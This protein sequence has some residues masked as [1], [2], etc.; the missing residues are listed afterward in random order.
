MEYDIYVGLFGTK[1]YYKKG[2]QLFHREDG[3]AIERLKGKERYSFTIE[4]NIRYISELPDQLWIDGCRLPLEKEIIL[5]K[6]YTNK[7]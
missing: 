2:T 4:N 1:F 5:N 3:P 7:G 6:W